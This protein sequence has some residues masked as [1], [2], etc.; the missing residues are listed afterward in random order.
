MAKQKKL[1]LLVLSKLGSQKKLSLKAGGAE[2][3]LDI[4][5]LAETL[6][7]GILP[8]MGM[9]YGKVV[10]GT[11]ARFDVSSETLTKTTL[12]NYGMRRKLISKGR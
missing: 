1:C 3:L 10:K 8:L 4:G 9:P 12:G 6:S 11:V 2:L 7:L 5:D